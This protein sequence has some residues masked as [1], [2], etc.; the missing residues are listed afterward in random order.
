MDHVS[1]IPA[2][3]ARVMLDLR[4]SPGTPTPR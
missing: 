2:Q 3:R 1:V 4:E